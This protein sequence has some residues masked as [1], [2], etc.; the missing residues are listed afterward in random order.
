MWWNSGGTDFYAA[1]ENDLMEKHNDATRNRPTGERV[2]DAQSVLIDI[3]AHVA[4]IRQEDAWIINDRNSITVF[5]TDDMCIVVGGLHEGAEMPPHKAEGIMS[6]QVLEGMLEVN[7]EELT[8]ILK[9][10][11]IIAIHKNCSYHFTA[12]EET[13]YLL[14]MSNVGA[15]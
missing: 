12:I 15:E 7:T 13:I 4:Q 8:G 14:T 5:K 9:R 6:I 10:G 1:T 11:Q 2:I 3:P